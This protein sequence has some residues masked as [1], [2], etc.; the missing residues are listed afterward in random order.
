MLHT[1]LSMSDTILQS[2]INITISN[3]K[4]VPQVCG[5]TQIVNR[6]QLNN[7]KDTIKEWINTEYIR[8]FDSSKQYTDS[9]NVHCV[10]NEEYMQFTI[11][12]LR[13][14]VLLNRGNV[15]LDILH[16]YTGISNTVNFKFE[17]E[18]SEED[19]QKINSVVDQLLNSMCNF[20]FDSP[21]STIHSLI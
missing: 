18:I 15:K 8:L 17:Y 16:S 19:K 20:E 7:A 4:R 3:N 1:T 11:I 6:T 21:N 9:I 12:V 10:K 2:P 5:T 14:G 13:H